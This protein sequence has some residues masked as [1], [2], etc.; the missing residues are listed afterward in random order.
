MEYVSFQ[1]Q[2]AGTGAGNLL[3]PNRNGNK[4]QEIQQEKTTNKI[5]IT[6][7]PD[8]NRQNKKIQTNTETTQ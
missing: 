5:K 6:K 1:C 7:D 8:I 4:T 2:Y 3:T